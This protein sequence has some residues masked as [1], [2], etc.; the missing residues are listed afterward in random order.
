VNRED[1]MMFIYE[2]VVANEKT[3]KFREQVRKMH[4]QDHHKTKDILEK[5][6]YA[7]QKIVVKQL[8]P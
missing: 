7:Y 5:W 4:W 3:D 2:Q 6:E 8:D 1:T